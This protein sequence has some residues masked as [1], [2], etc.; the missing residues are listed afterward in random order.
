MFDLGAVVASSQA[1]V[2][3]FLKIEGL[4]GE[5]I[6]VVNCGKA[7]GTQVKSG[8]GDYCRLPASANG[9]QGLPATRKYFVPDTSTGASGGPRAFSGDASVLSATKAPAT[10]TLQR[11]DRPPSPAPR[12]PTRSWDRSRTTR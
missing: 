3:Y 1:A 6:S 10:K 7:G 2:D 9:P 4:K 11:Q 5:A 12:T 8:G